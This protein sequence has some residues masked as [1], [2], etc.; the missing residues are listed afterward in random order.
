MSLDFAVKENIR[1][2]SFCEFFQDRNNYSDPNMAY[3]EKC[4]DA[5]LNNNET[6][7][8]FLSWPKTT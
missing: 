2:A 1:W 7:Q 4:K 3:A 8:F 6:K 5:S